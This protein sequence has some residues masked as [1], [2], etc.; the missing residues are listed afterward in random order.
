MKAIPPTTATWMLK[1]LASAEGNEE[2]EGDLLEEFQ[3]RRSASWYWRQVLL[4]IL[5][6]PNASRIAWLTF[7]AAIFAAVWVSGLHTIS[8]LMAHF[9]FQAAFGNWLDRESYGKTIWVA[10][11][12]AFY[13][14]GPVTVYLALARNLSLRSLAVGVGVGVLTIFLF[15]LVQPH[16]YTPLSYFFAYALAKHWN[17]TLW[18]RWYDILQGSQAPVGIIPLLVAMC[19][20]SLCR[21]RSPK[22]D[23][24][25]SPSD[26]SK[27]AASLQE[28]STGA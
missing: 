20:A 10:E 26:E 27:P 13:L 18:L 12:I 9:R 17:V 1:H 21:T 25:E 24:K 14:A 16:L 19:A 6:F 15:P 7:W 11:G 23:P 2:L 28:N 3:R 5:A 22:L 8:S 4:A